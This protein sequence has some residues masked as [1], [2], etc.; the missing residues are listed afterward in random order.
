MYDFEKVDRFI[1]Y[2]L[3]VCKTKSSDEAFR[4]LTGIIE[5]TEEQYINEYISVLNYLQSA[6]VLDW[7]EQQSEKVKNASSSW[8]Q[9]AASSKF[10]WKRAEKWINSGRPLSLIALDA[11][12][13]CTTTNERLN[14]SPWT[15]ELNPSL[16]DMPRSEK[17]AELIIK[18]QSED[19]VPRVKNAV[20]TIIKNLY[21]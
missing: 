4:I 14:Q 3:E 2:G 10:D 17:I 6:K 8:G 20:N 19:N 1:E 15:R 11:L 9:L 7:I 18:Y 21:E 5:K 13:L 12:K 16:N